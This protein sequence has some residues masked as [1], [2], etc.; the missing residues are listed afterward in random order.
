MIKYIHE[1]FF[2]FINMCFS[3]QMR[4]H[5]T[6][7]NSS[8]QALSDNQLL[9]AALHKTCDTGFEIQLTF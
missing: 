7:A 4:F 3:P 1:L 9:F 5:Q 2:F 8:H 6:W